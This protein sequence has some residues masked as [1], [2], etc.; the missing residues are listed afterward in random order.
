MNFGRHAR[1]TI[2]SATAVIAVMA[3]SPSAYA[4]DAKPKIVFVSPV[5]NDFFI[6]VAAGLKAA[7]EQ[8]GWDYQ[9]LGPPTYDAAKEADLM[10]TSMRTKPDAIAVAFADAEAFKKPV[11]DALAAGIIVLGYNTDVPSTGRLG[12]VGQDNVA[13]GKSAAE[14]VLSL[15]QGKG[16]SKGAIILVT[17]NFG[18]VAQDQRM[19]GFQNAIANT[20]FKVTVLA[21]GTTDAQYIGSLEAQFR[22]VPEVV[23][24]FGVDVMSKD[25]ATFVEKNKLSG[26]LVSGGWNQTDVHLDAIKS[27]LMDF[28]VGP[29]PFLQGYFPVVLAQLR[30]VYG[31]APVTI[32]TGA[33]FV[34]KS[35][36]DEI[37]AREAKWK[38]VAK[39]RWH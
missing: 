36:V 4:A 12:Y 35:N 32:D 5:T 7:A 6:P 16:V 39:T 24:I 26:K 17:Q 3:G 34:D 25:I 15:L 13:A 21:G 20:P 27:G 22:A 31:Y 1:R 10:L 29:N 37:A 30:K 14:R 23:A 33:E 2:L 28:T 19:K 8:Y 9:F 38:E 11:Q 18:N